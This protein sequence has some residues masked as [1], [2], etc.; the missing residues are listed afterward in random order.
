MESEQENFHRRVR[1]AYLERAENNPEKYAVID[2]SQSLE[3]VQNDLHKVLD[4]L[5]QSWKNK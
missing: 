3:Q 2:A 4:D 1:H 5:V